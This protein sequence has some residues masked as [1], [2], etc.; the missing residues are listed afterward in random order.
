MVR[1]ALRQLGVLV[2][3]DQHKK[4]PP[5]W[6]EFL[7]IDSH[8]RWIIVGF[9]YYNPIFPKSQGKMRKKSHKG[10]ACH[11]KVAS[12]KDEKPTIF[13]PPLPIAPPQPHRKI[14]YPIKKGVDILRHRLP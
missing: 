5:E 7:G 10:C 9:V 4:I 8:R 3:E 6:L 12:Q 2:T 11:L 14:A 13:P 1:K